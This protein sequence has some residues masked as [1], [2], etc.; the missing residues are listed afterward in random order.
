MY[1]HGHRSTEL[2]PGRTE[3][4][5]RG[6]DDK[7]PPS[8][9]G[10]IHFINSASQTGESSMHAVGNGIRKLA[11]KHASKVMCHLVCMDAKSSVLPISQY[12][13]S[14]QISQD[15]GKPCL[16][17][18]QS[19]SF[20][21]LHHVYFTPGAQITHQGQ[22]RSPVKYHWVPPLTAMPLCPAKGYTSH[23]SE[24]LQ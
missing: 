4:K 18:S 22:H 8:L 9:T 11:W 14:C 15:K 17:I 21:S 16:P 7:K 19:H 3:L 12:G 6:E 20:L 13:T 10:R 1:R 23:F 24:A 5:G 2:F